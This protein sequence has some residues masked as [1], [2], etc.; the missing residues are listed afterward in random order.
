MTENIRF[1]INHQ[2]M[3]SEKKG[4]KHWLCI[5]SIRFLFSIFPSTCFFVNKISER[6]LE[7]NR[8]NVISIYKLVTDD[9]VYDNTSQHGRIFHSL[10]LSQFLLA[11]PQVLKECN[12]YTWYIIYIIY[13]MFEVHFALSCLWK[14]TEN[15]WGRPLK[16]WC[17]STFY[18]SNSCILKFKFYFYFKMRA[19]EYMSV[20]ALIWWFTL[21]IFQMARCK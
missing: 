2:R 3:T 8:R 11:W 16:F 6:N 15:F 20:T 18:L 19:G 7:Y 4:A 9:P 14:H 10:I 1:V 13:F 21:Q 17:K 12:K 5:I